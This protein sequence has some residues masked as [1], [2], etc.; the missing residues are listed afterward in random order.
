MKVLGERHRRWRKPAD[1][2]PG[3]ETDVK[4]IHECTRPLPAVSP[5]GEP[6]GK[7]ARLRVDTA[8]APVDR[9]AI[10]QA[11]TDGSVVGVEDELLTD[12]SFRA[13]R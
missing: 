12:R 13:G 3:L 2:L 7:S 8:V 9:F 1:R 6:L 11:L 5:L 4:R 10:R